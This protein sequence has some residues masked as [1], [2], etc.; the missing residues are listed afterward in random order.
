[1]LTLALEVPEQVLA[2]VSVGTGGPAALVRIQLTVRA[3]PP[4]WTHALVPVDAILARPS[5]QAG[6]GMAL[7]NVCC[8]D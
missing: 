3:L 1:V 4:S 2:D 6:A 7:V 5:V 8:K